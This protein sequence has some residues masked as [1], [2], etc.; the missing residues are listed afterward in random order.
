MDLFVLFVLFVVGFA[1][2]GFVVGSYY[3]YRYG[4]LLRFYVATAVKRP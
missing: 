4:A 3:R 1:V 2:G